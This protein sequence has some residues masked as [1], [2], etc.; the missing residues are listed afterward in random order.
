MHDDAMGGRVVGAIGGDHVEVRQA[1]VGAVAGQEV[2]ITNGGV[3]AIAARRDVSITNGGSGPIAAGGTVSI[4]NGGAQTIATLGGATLGPR[5]FVAF[6]L[7]PK[8]TIEQ[9]A[10]VLMSTPQA[11]AFGAGLGCAMALIK[12]RGTRR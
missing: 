9:G 3:G 7:S 5:S 10:K 12:R 8:V 6:V 2:S 11:L 4:M 1:A